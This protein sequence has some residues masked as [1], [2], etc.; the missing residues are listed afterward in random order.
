[1]AALTAYGEALG[2]AFQITDDLLD[3]Q[4]ETAVLGKTVGSDLK[5]EK[6]T[7]PGMVG[8]TEARQFAI[9]EINRACQVLLPLAE[10]GDALRQLAEAVLHRDR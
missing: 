8:I 3:L 2:L 9:A 5:N 7:Y 4:A 6:A 1:M 10:K